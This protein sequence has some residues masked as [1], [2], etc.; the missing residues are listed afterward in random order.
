MAAA[1]K[2]NYRGHLVRHQ[3]V[4]WSAVVEESKRDDRRV[5]ILGTEL[6]GLGSGGRSIL[7]HG[8]AAFKEQGFSR[9]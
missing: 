3:K 1:R 9:G 8:G 7:S 4:N 6:W 2:F 5:R